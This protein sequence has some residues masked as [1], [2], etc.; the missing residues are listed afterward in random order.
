M[1]CL[2]MTR[3]KPHALSLTLEGED[4]DAT[5][6]Q[7]DCASNTHCNPKRCKPPHCRSAAKL[8]AEPR[9]RDST[10]LRPAS[11]T[12]LVSYG[13]C[14]TPTGSMVPSVPQPL[15]SRDSDQVPCLRGATLCPCTY[16]MQR[17]CASHVC[18]PWGEWEEFS[19]PC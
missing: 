10:F 4:K 13:Y 17:P 16:G 19:A 11:L 1:H 5:L 6:S 3:S 7:S 15:V 18:R 2:A 9:S 12:P 8:H 14:A